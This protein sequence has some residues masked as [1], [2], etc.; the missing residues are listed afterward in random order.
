VA[1]WWLGR[2]AA[3]SPPDARLESKARIIFVVI[4][5]LQLFFRQRVPLILDKYVMLGSALAE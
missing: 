4:L 3:A 5:L 1:A 2:A